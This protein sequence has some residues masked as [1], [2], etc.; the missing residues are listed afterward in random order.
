M[1]LYRGPRRLILVR[2]PI[3]V[4]AGPSYTKSANTNGAPA[5]GILT[6]TG[7]IGT[8]TATRVVLIAVYTQNAVA[9]AA[10]VGGQA[11]TKIFT[12]NFTTWW[13]YTGSAAGSGVQTITVTG[14]A[15][16]SQIAQVWYMDGL[17]STT[18]LNSA[19][20]TNSTTT[21]TTNIAITAGDLL[22]ATAQEASAADT[23][24]F[25]TSTETPANQGSIT[26]SP[27]TQG[28]ADW[29]TSTTNAAWA[30]TC[31]HTNA[32]QTFQSGVSF[33]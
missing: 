32:V 5:S 3:V 28:F 12:S 15:F 20:A 10:T 16:V 9:T 26:L 23:I 4:A 30:I 27:D 29:K 14:G 18:M 17:N 13:Q 33:R 24:T 2:K 31:I 21:L 1:P 25:T 22:F 11:A 19:T 8:A 7:D 6:W